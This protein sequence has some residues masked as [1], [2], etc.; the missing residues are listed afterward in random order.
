MK[1]ILDFSHSEARRFLLKEKSYYNF[2]LPQYF[3]FQKLLDQISQEIQEKPLQSYYGS[4]DVNGKNKSTRPCDYENVNYRFF[5]N[6]DGKFSWRPLQL[7]H[8][9][10]YVSLTHNISKEENWSVIVSRM[11][12]FSN[13]P[14][15]RCLSLPVESDDKISDKAA[16]VNN[17]WYSVEQKSI[18]L[19][20]KYQYVVHT[21]I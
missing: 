15:I 14:K 10:I 16:T 18:E 4:I 1:K 7:I 11:N 2:D 21:D 13:N 20:L 19:A 17:W 3:V 9:A 5:N 12:E 8:P 6:K